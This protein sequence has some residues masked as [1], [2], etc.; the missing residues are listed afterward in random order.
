MAVKHQLYWHDGNS[1]LTTA[2]NLTPPRRIRSGT[3]EAAPWWAGNSIRMGRV[4]VQGQS[5]ILCLKELVDKGEV[6]SWR[7][8]G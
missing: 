8:A 6:A 5:M 4:K 7:I 2:E 1:T 3:G